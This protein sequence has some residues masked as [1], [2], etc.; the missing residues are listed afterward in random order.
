MH[1]L[2]LPFSVSEG[3]EPPDAARAVEVAAGAMIFVGRLPPALTP[4]GPAFERLWNLRPPDYAPFTIH[5]RTVPTPR[6]TQ[7]YAH[8]Y[9]YGGRPHPALPAPPEVA[10][11]LLWAQSTTDPRLNGVVVNWYD[12][13]L[14]HYIGA[15]RDSRESLVAGAPIVNICLGEDRPFRIRPW[16]GRGYRDFP[17]P[18]G[19]VFVIPWRTNLV[20]T[21]EVPLLKAHRDR[22]ISVAI[23]AFRPP[24]SAPPTDA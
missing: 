18:H 3:A 24:T 21:H 9:V 12:A 4:D 6:W 14:G 11:F 5:G 10:P 20:V 23:R 7:P 15:H 1:Q 17:A 2:P 22:R 19:T 16:K 13:R 8:D